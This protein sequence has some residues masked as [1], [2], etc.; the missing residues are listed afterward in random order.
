MAFKN[1][2]FK[3]LIVL[4]V[5]VVLCVIII[6]ISFKQSNI[7][8]SLRTVSLDF[9]NPI[10]EK[11]YSFF[12]PLLKF[13]LSIKNY[14]DLNQKLELL[15]KENA[16]LLKD[17]AENINLKIEN[18]ALRKLIGLEIRK[19]YDTVP[20]KVIGYYDSK[21]QSEIIINVGK[22]SGVYEG[23][24]VVNEKGLIGIIIASAE[25][26]SQVR[27][28]TDPQSSIGARILSS[29][30]LG[31][32]EGGIDKLAYLNYIKISEDVFKGDVLITA[33]LNDLIPE[34]ILI[35]RVSK[36]S[37]I[38][39]SPYKKIVVDLFADFK[40]VEYVLV[41]KGLKK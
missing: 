8:Q 23:M 1:G 18:N 30:K 10:Q 14:I 15:E 11:V 29:R 16:S 26:S 12:N 32:V 5:I 7:F 4:L 13:F 39:T 3:N 38:P 9:L 20:A 27:L 37:I 28:L 41:I 21:W 24:A 25:K 19:D 17:Y 35:G 2:N 33:G 40:E 36:I 22:T 34:G 31:V 6:T